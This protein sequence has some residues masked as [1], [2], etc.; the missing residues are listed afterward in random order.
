MADQPLTQ[1]VPLPA[2]RAAWDAAYTIY[3][4]RLAL[5]DADEKFGPVKRAQG[6][7]AL[8]KVDL[9]LKFGKCWQDHP[10]AQEAA[11]AASA[12]MERAEQE[13]FDRSVKP[14]YDAQCA[15]LATPAPD[16]DAVRA[17]IDIMATYAFVES[18]VGRPPETIIAEDVERLTGIVA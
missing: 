9:T 8:A 11:E 14:M 4:A 18:D 6:E 17:K 13:Y 10:D 1:S 7:N 3:R 5:H 2:T 16:L 12:A 15:L